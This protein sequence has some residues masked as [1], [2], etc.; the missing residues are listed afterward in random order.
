MDEPLLF[1]HFILARMNQTLP[2]KLL[3]ILTNTP[4]LENA[5]LVGGCVRD[6]ILGLPC[7]DYD[8][9]AF[10]ISYEALTKAL[11]RWGK[12]N[13]VGKSFGV[14][15]LSV[16]GAIYDFSIPRRDS[17]IAVGHK[18]FHAELDG[19]LSMEEATARRDFT[20]NSLLYDPRSEKIIDLHGG[21]KDLEGRILRHTSLAFT[22]D[23]LRVLRGMQFV[24]RFDL[25]PAPETIELCRQ[26]KGSFKELARERVR[27][28]WFKWAEK[29][30]RPSRGLHFLRDTEWIGHFPEVERMIGVPQDPEWHPEGDVYIHTCHCLDALAQLPEF[31]ASDAES[32]IVLMFAIL[33]H[34]FGKVETTFKE[35]RNGILR[36]VSPGHEQASARLAERFLQSLNAPE[37]VVRR[38]LP[39]A[40]NHMA[41]LHGITEKAVRRLSKKLQPES[42]EH[43]ATVMS[44]D[45]M[46][47]PPKPAVVS[48]GVIQLRELARQLNV[49][50]EAPKPILLGRNLVECGYS[51][52]PSMGEMLAEA[53]DAQL[54]GA[55]SDM[56]GA[57][58]WVIEKQAHNLPP[59]VYEHIRRKN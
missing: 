12:S 14:V 38:V 56:A 52:G 6:W 57:W 58:K 29:S 50:L 8:V 33:T 49:A 41:H 53:Y 37:F 45:Q 44:A 32:R 21:L 4:E 3:E 15:K 43:L 54:N 5:Y 27:D 16:D 23:P 17:K 51:P 59:E 22:E 34:D 13:M 48:Q 40:A 46:G 19:N 35:M 39:L 47:R 26:I 7:K 18:G 42:I 11:S 2:K 10:G 9:E 28:E 25:T 30:L 31:L 20:I 24:A 55:F 1:W 36:V